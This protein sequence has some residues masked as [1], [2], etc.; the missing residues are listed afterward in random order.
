MK[1]LHLIGGGDEGGAKSHVLSLVQQLGN[2]ISVKL[3]CAPGD[4]SVAH[5]RHRTVPRRMFLPPVINL[6]SKTCQVIYANF[7]SVVENG[8][9]G[10]TPEYLV[11]F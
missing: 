2:H 6:L 10:K 7:S 9:P 3:K 8:L 5:M 1:V 4:G 11:L